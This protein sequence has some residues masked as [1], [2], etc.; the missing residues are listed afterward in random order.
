MA[1]ASAAATV[2]TSKGQAA[3]NTAERYAGK[4]HT[5]ATKR[6]YRSD[7]AHF[8]DWCQVHGF[9]AMPAEPRAVG[10]HLA[11]LGETHALNNIR[12]RLSAIGKAHQVNDLAWNPG[13][14][15][16]R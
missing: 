16:I 6:A 15:D 3:L 9:I 12:P 5:Y 7:W 4:A 13:H 1:D 14:R 10:A 8:D 2:L 11:S